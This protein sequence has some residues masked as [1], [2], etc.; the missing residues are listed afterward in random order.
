MA[1]II[2]SSIDA[3]IL[4]SAGATQADRRRRALAAVG[5]FRAGASEIAERHDAALDEAFDPG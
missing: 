3:E 1:D 5:R 4:R 2:R